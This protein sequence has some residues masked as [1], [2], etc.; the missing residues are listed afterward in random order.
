[1]FE[2]TALPIEGTALPARLAA[3]D[4][5]ALVV[6]EGRVRNH[7]L[8]DLDQVLAE[9]YAKHIENISSLHELNRW[10]REPG[11]Q[12]RLCISEADLAGG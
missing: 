2:L 12:E 10:L 9:F 8:G 5:G 6:F 4:A 1:M 11:A 3:P 7:H